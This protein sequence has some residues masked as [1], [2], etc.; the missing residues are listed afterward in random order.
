MHVAIIAAEILAILAAW[1][2]LSVVAGFLLG[3]ALKALGK[4]DRHD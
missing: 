1:F 3:K 2:A 4:A